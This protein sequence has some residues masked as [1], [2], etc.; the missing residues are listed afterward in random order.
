M[1]DTQNR[2]RGLGQLTLAALPYTQRLAVV[3]QPL[4]RF[5][6]FSTYGQGFVGHLYP[7]LLSFV[8]PGRLLPFL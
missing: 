6:E 2:V 8:C 7:F 5:P 1:F 3:R 4:D